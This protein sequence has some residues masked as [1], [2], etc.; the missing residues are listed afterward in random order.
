MAAKRRQFTS[1]FERYRTKF[2]DPRSALLT[3][4]SPMVPGKRLDRPISERQVNFWWHAAIALAEKREKRELALSKGNA[5]HGLRYNRRT[6][7]RN[8]ELKYARWLVGHSVTNGTAGIEVSEG[9]Y[10]G[11]KPRELAAAV[12]VSDV[13]E[14]DEDW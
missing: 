1:E 12:L 10:L 3:P 9:I 6:E 14:D 4:D 7:L 2:L 8:V 11:L 13:G 5:Y